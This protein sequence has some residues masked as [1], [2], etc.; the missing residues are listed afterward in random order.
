MASRKQE[1]KWGGAGAGSIGSYS[2][3]RGCTGFV[4]TGEFR[5]WCPWQKYWWLV[6][7]EAALSEENKL[8]KNWNRNLKIKNEAVDTKK[9]MDVEDDYWQSRDKN[10]IS[11]KSLIKN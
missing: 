1:K 8:L 4:I 9:L 2:C 3:R 6:S 7:E 11:I 10:D 5:K